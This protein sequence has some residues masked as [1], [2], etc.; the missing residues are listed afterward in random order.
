MFTFYC[1][2]LISTPI[3]VTTEVNDVVCVLYSIAGLDNVLSSNG[4]SSLVVEAMLL[5]TKAYYCKCYLSNGN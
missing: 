3:N 5:K 4:A 2:S 1:S